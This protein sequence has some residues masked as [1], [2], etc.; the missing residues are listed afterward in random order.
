MP[1]EDNINLPLLKNSQGKQSLFCVVVASCAVVL[2]CICD[3][4]IFNL[5]E[6]FGI[7]ALF[8]AFYVAAWFNRLEIWRILTGLIGACTISLWWWS[9]RQKFPIGYGGTLLAFS[10]LSTGFLAMYAVFY[11]YLK[12]KRAEFNAQQD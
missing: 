4:S 5:L 10:G 3:H 11:R 9:S 7:G 1:R 8:G 12:Q 2:C 6:V